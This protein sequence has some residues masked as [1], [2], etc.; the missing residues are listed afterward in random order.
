VVVFEEHRVHLQLVGE[1]EHGERAG[2][3]DMLTGRE[4]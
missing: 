4:R 1:A 2:H 3:G